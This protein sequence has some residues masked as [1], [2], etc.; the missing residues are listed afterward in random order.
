MK[1]FSGLIAIVAVLGTA[2]VAS[3]DLISLTSASNSATGS[4]TLTPGGTTIN[5]ATNALTDG[6]KAGVSLT[7]TGNPSYTVSGGAYQVFTGGTATITG[8][9]DGPSNL[10]GS[11]TGA[12]HSISGSLDVTAD[13]QFTINSE[14]LVTVVLNSSLT[15]LSGGSGTVYAEFLQG[16]NVLASVS[17]NSLGTSYTAVLAAGSYE[18]KAVTDLTGSSGHSFAVPSADSGYSFTATAVPEPSTFALL[19]L[20]GLGLAITAV[21]RRR[22]QAAAV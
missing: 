10:A 6:T 15:T 1:K 9:A 16:T 11:Y 20:G 18:L 21:R 7:A 8:N 22:Q 13:T 14:S 17:G 5:T 12:G 4:I 2:G 19:G 3:A